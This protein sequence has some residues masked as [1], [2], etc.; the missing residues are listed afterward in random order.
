MILNG[1][2]LDELGVDEGRDEKA[3]VPECGTVCE[4]LDA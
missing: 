4:T 2:Y 3:I 1:K